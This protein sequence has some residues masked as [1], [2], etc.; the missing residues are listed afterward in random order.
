MPRTLE[1]PSERVERMVRAHVATLAPGAQLPAVKAWA[2][3]LKTSRA[4]LGRVI[5][6]LEA[7][8]LVTI[9]VG[10]GTFKAEPRP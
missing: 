8:G 10:W 7:E 2:L 4:T 1:L 6:K 3:E 9:V 5:K